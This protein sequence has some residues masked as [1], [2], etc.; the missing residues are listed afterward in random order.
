MG[1]DETRWHF[2]ATPSALIA[3]TRR[4]VGRLL[5]P[6]RPENPH[7]FIRD[8]ASGALGASACVEP[9]DPDTARVVGL[10]RTLDACPG[11]VEQERPKSPR[12]AF[13]DAE[14]PGLPPARYLG[15]A[16]PGGLGLT[17]LSPARVVGRHR[18]LEG[19]APLFPLPP[20]T[21]CALA[22]TTA[23]LVHHPRHE[24][25]ESLAA[26][27]DPAP[28]FA[29]QARELMPAGWTGLD[30]LRAPALH[31]WAL[32]RRHRLDGE[33]AEVWPPGRFTNGLCIVPL[34]LLPLDVGLPALGRPPGD[35]GPAFLD[36]ACPGRGR[37]HRLP[38]PSRMAPDWPRRGS[39]GPEPGVGGG[40]PSRA[41]SRRAPATVS[42]MTICC[43]S[44]SA[45]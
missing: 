31:G 19:A 8:G 30:A 16:L 41:C 36:G 22:P 44:R 5:G 35:R 15:E 13:A 21:A 40:P 42:M 18:R 34:R 38:A 3:G 24:L 28:V 45:H 17:P 11:A 12:A 29:Q 32:L 14:E 25:A 26:L 27:G 2:N 10:C 9:L 39:V 4:P 7:I 6:E 33:A 37:P 43:S 23:P 1:S 20:H